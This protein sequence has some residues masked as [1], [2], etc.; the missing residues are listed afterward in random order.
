MNQRNK[1][2]EGDDMT[3]KHEE[4]GTRERVLDAA[5]QLFAE[6]GYTATSMRA[7]TKAAKVNLGAVNYHFGAK[8][9]LLCAVV[10]RR[11]APINET[12]LR[13]L[14]VCEAEAGGAPL[15]LEAILRAFI[16]PVFRLSE[17]GSP[18]EAAF[19]QLIGRLYSEP[20]ESLSQLYEEQFGEVFRRFSAALVRALPELT[21][22]ELYW[23]LQ[24]TIGMLTHTLMA[25]ERLQLCTEGLCDPD[26]A[27]AIVERMVRFAS[28]GM[29]SPVSHPPRSGVPSTSPAT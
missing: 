1:S 19:L 14:D 29:R 3:A 27:D 12:R 23:R 26:E 6:R 20:V 13:L 24:F 28:A 4:K 21:M 11:V 10:L 2:R 18:G 16:A 25:G 8:E 22:T 15:P 17:S 7:I 9:H 5:E